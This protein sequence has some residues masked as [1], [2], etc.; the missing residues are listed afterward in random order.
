MPAESTEHVTP[1]GWQAGRR[2]VRA[3][4][5]PLER[6]LHVQAASGIVLLV[7]AVAALAWVNLL[8]AESY[9]RFW[10]L[11]I[12]LGAGAVMFTRSLHFW[13]NDGLMTLF[14]FVVGLEIR[15][16]IHEGELSDLRRAALPLAAAL[17]GMLA[18][19]GIYAA[20][21][22]GTPAGSGW[23]VPMATDIAF[24]VGVLTLLGSRVRP[25]LR[26][27]LL[28]VA[29]VDDIGAIAVIAVFYADGFSWV[30]AV[31]A[32]G[33]VGMAWLLRQLGA[34]N[35]WVFVP[36]GVVAWAG[37]LVAGVHPTL[38]GVA[39]G[40]L[41]PVRSPIG[42]MGFLAKASGAV[43][44]FRTRFAASPDDGAA[45]AGPLDELR[46]A[47]ED[48]LAPVTRLELALHPWVAFLI[49]PVFALA[50]AG[51]AVGSVDLGAV[52]ATRLNAGIVLGLVVGK[53]V[54]VVLASF[55]VV[56]LGWAALPRGV[57]WAGVA[58]VGCVAGVGFT[59]AIFIAGLAFTSPATLSVAK[60]AVL[61]GSGISIAVGLAVGRLALTPRP[62]DED[63][64]PNEGDAEAAT[65]Y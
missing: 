57:T 17:G 4:V 51:V 43:A 64:A 18:P 30:G 3:L 21:N 39:L 35:P 41:T 53:P 40:M 10:H 16:E 11:P 8:G 42:G 60:L 9:E 56:G 32:C 20:L 52:S 23:G 62:T 2:A 48:A 49:M 19:A 63:S 33:G 58:I 29:I 25:A 12:H 13:V 31:M 46:K 47:R 55:A 24:A 61:V 1:G 38:S 22:V 7:A 27:L 28:A 50:N 45:L 5:R 59:M 6:F 15:R 36:A 54:G 44:R 37:L 14:F 34:R 65:D 26:V